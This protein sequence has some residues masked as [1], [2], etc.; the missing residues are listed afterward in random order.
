MY[1]DGKPTPRSES[2]VIHSAG[3][4]ANVLV[5]VTG[6]LP[7]RAWSPPA[8]AK[9]VRVEGCRFEPHVAAMMLGQWVEFRN[10]DEAP[11]SVHPLPRI[12]PEFGIGQ[13]ARDQPLVRW[14][15][16][17]PEIGVVTKCDVHAW[18]SCLLHILEHPFFSVSNSKGE[19][20]ILNLPPGEYEISA[21]HEMKSAKFAAMP[22]K[23]KV[24]AG[25]TTQVMIEASR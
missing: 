11:H 22:I 24:E 8:E 3:G 20:E 6:G 13:P 9:I 5:H 2:W 19:F 16:T 12:N 17:R 10:V 15:P 7:D 1:Y 23:I 21:T 14:Q 4:L 18:M 25:K